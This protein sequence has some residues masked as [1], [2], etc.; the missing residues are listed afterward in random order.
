M[1]NYR[2]RLSDMMPNAWFYKLKDMGRIRNHIINSHPVKKKQL[3]RTTSPQPSQPKQQQRQHQQPPFSHGR[4]SYY[5]TTD[6]FMADRLYNSPTNTKAFDNHIPDPEPPRKSSRRKAK[7]RTMRSSSKLVTSSVSAGCSCRATFDSVWTKSNS[8]PDYSSSPLESSPDPDFHESLL[9]EFCCSDHVVPTDPF[10]GLGSWSSSCCCRVNPS[11]TD[12]IIDAKDKSFTRDFD[13]LDRFD[14]FAQL[15]LSPILTKPAKFSDMIRDMKKKDATT[16]PAKFKRY[17]T[18]LEE[19][20]EHRS[21][22]VKVV[23]HEHVKALKE[24]RIS[25]PPRRQLPVSPGFKLRANSP[26]IASR[27]IQAYARKSVSSTPSS[28]PRRKSLSESFAVVKSSFDPQ[29]DFRDSMVE[30]VV[31]NN[32]RASKDLEE[33]LACYLSLNSDEYHDLIVKVFEQIWFGL[34]DIRL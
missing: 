7:R 25:P 12:I 9:S 31:E 21:L 3:N 29:R 2:F 34:T 24:Q 8:T 16:E 28:R 30:M 1:G 4:R 19:T 22:S 14:S 23:K 11:A 32:I 17:S 13:K 6:P 18:K 20:K 5:Y 10:H 26:R 27:K 33:L 15:E